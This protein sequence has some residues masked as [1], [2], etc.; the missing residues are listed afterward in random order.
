MRIRLA[1]LAVGVPFV[2]VRA[3][4]LIGVGTRM[5]VPGRRE[6]RRTTPNS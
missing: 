1:V 2:S 4:G 3:G 6:A 5:F